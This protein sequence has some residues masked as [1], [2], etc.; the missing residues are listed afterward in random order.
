M[1]V[2]VTTVLG[3]G[4]SRASA[5]AALYVITADDIRRSGHR[6]LAEALR[7]VPAMY[8]GRLNSSSWVIGAR[9]LTGSAITATR[10]LVLIDERVVY[11]PL[12]SATF[13][14]TTDVPLAD[15]DRIEVIRGPG[16]TLWGANAMN[17]VVNVITKAAADTQ[18]AYALVGA[19]SY[20]QGYA[21]L[22]YGG[23][24]G[25]GAFRTYLKYA[26]RDD[27]ENAQ[28]V[29]IDD[30]WS[31]LRTGFRA[32]LP[33]DAATTVTLSGDVYEHPVARASVRVPVPGQHLQFQQIAQ[34]D[35][36][37]GAHL[38]AR[39][40]RRHGERARS[41]MHAYYDRTRRFGA[42]LA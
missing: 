26:N 24:I 12:I 2:E 41:T 11:D 39:A 20:E 16:A 22:R 6:T 37:S 7:L 25:S 38:I 33:V 4:Q 35:D 40:E 9:G 31:S 17:G 18:G 3:S 30:A 32:D 15:I 36:I 8:V 19:G 28:G 23:R 42:R 13:W 14:D 34:N 1:E 10:Y 21:T 27:F 5:P 29:S